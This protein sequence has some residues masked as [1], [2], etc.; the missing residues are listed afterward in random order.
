MQLKLLK[1]DYKTSKTGTKFAIANVSNESGAE[2]DNVT[3]FSN[4]P[5]FEGLKDG[6]TIEG[7]LVTNDYNGRKGWKLSTGKPMRAKT[8]FKKAM[9]T[10][11]DNIK[12][13]QENKNESIKISS[14]FRDA[15]ILTAE[16]LKKTDIS[17]MTDKDIQDKWLEWR[18][19]LWKQFDSEQEPF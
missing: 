19:W 7:D 9:E 8:D 11:A 17:F 15:T 10:K 13:A 12:V 18:K 14:T 2:F 1:I 6:A 3:I 4:Y 16:W 5:E